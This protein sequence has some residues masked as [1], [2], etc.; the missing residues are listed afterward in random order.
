[1]AEVARII[2][3]IQG[4]QLDRLVVD[5]TGMQGRYDLQISID[6]RTNVPSPGRFGG[7]AS[8]D[9]GRVFDQIS[10]ADR[11]PL[12]IRDALR[13]Q[14]GLTLDKAKL[15]IPTLTIERAKRPEED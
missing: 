6:L 3:R 11:R 10:L 5:G 8:A 4:F 12:A 7:G 13:E 9:G 1:M 14:L 2:P 15:T